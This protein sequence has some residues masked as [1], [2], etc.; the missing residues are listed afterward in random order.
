MVVVILPHPRIPFIRLSVLRS[1]A[2]VKDHKGGS[3][4]DLPI[5]PSK[6]G[7]VMDSDNI[8]CCAAHGATT[9]Y[10][11]RMKGPLTFL[12]GPLEAADLHHDKT[13]NHIIIIQ[14][15]L[16]PIIFSATKAESC[17]TKGVFKGLWIR[18]EL[19]ATSS[20][21]SHVVLANKDSVNFNVDSMTD[22]YS[23]GF[24]RTT[25]PAP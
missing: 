8:V 15:P 13:R 23:T 11:L 3:H 21:H 7:S 16:R 9:W 5:S 4:S 24:K 20:A 18:I 17:I 12:L 22:S 1:F 10:P 19:V 14:K 2:D 25:L 6:F